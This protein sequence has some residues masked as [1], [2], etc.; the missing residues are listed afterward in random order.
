VR[1]VLALVF[2]GCGFQV[3]NGATDAPVSGDGRM[4][5]A[6]NMGSGSGSG[7]S[8]PTA[9]NYVQ[10][11]WGEDQSEQSQA[12]AMPN[13]QHAGNLNIVAVGW[14]KTGTITSISDTQ[15]NTYQIAVGPTMTPSY[16]ESQTIFYACG[17]AGGANSVTV[18]FADDNQDPEVRVVEYSGAQATGCYDTSVA[19]T[20]SGTA[21][22]SGTM[23]AGAGELLVAADKVYNL[24]SEPD[25][26][27]AMRLKS[28]FGDIVEDRPA[29]TAGSYHAT[30]TENIAGV[31]VMQLATFR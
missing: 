7:S 30:A 22:D 31:W 10:S 15:H 20:G 23:T 28:D 16:D 21:V 26:S 2:A 27:Y 24:T 4:G 12:V 19:N 5:D 3:S 11:A 13:A 6:Q 8:A 18:A 9:I 1:V 29:M 14:Y 25:P 17:I